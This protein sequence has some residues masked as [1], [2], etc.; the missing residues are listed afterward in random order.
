[1]ELVE[2]DEQ[3]SFAEVSGSALAEKLKNLQL[4][5]MTP[6]ECMNILYELKKEAETSS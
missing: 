1:M 3:I 6:L 5:S 4:D 2:E